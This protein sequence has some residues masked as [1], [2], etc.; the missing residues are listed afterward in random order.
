MGLT[1][2][3]VDQKKLEGSSLDKKMI[4]LTRVPLV[5]ESMDKSR[6][7][8]TAICITSLDI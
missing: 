7:E 3:A 1:N 6:V 8:Q 5:E 2:R 4:P